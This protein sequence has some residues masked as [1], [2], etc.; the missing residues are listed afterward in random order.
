[1]VTLWLLIMTKPLGSCVNTRLFQTDNVANCIP[2]RTMN[3][4]TTPPHLGLKTTADGLQMLDFTLTVQP[5]KHSVLIYIGTCQQQ[6]AP[7]QAQETESM[8]PIRK[9]KLNNKPKTTQMHLCVQEY[10]YILEIQAHFVSICA[11][12]SQ[13]YGLG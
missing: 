5:S 4:L 11:N 8:H 7:R 1:M 12:K 10:I 6:P 2:R 9:A 3:I 13:N